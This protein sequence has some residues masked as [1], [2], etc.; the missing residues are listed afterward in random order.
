MN[1]GPI[2]YERDADG[3]VT[4]TWDC[5]GPVNVLSAQSVDAFAQ[6]VA[7]VLDD[8]GAV[9][10]VVASAKR[11]FIVGLDLNAVGAE[12]VA[13]L[14][15]GVDAFAATTRRMETGGKTFVAALAGTALGG[16]AELALA[17]HR[18]IASAGSDARFGFPEVTLGLIPGGGATQRLPRLSG[19]VQALPLLLEGRRLR[20]ADAAKLGIIDELVAD[21]ELLGAAKSWA[22]ANPRAAQPWDARTFVFPGG[23]PRDPG[24]AEALGVAA[25][26]LREKTWGNYPA[27]RD[28]LAAVYEGAL[29]DLESGLRVEARYFRAAIARPEARAMVKTLFFSMNRAKRMEARPASV[30]RRSFG[31]VGVVGAGTMG[32]GIALAAARAGA[33]AIVLDRDGLQAE[34][35]RSHA[36]AHGADAVT[37]ARIVPTTDYAAFAPC[38]LVIEAVFEDRAVK[39][40]VIARVEAN[41]RPE[42]ILAS[43]TSTLPIGSLAASSAQPERFVGI[44]FFSPVER[45]SLVE[46]IRGRATGDAALAAALDFAHFLGKTPIVVNDGR[47][48]FTSRVFATYVHEG[49]AMLREG[50]RPATIENAGRLAGMAVGP[51]AVA[52]EVGFALLQSVVEATRRDLGAAYVPG[53][54]DDVIAAFAVELARSG[55]TAGRGV[56]DYAPGVKKTLWPGLAE[57]WKP[58]AP[59]PDIE[60][61]KHRLLYVQAL[62]A[63]RCQLEGVIADPAMGDVASILGW[64]F[65]AFSGGVFSFVE[66]VGA[67]AFEAERARLAT[68]YGARFAA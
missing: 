5:A 60:T 23:T 12:R 54:A 48:F 40:D 11:D 51:L 6:A 32:A 50:V 20:L 39:E 10:A 18:R 47:G 55:K 25:A 17:C 61:V 15:D 67:D 41:V 13:S 56:Y 65:P 58:R 29:L 49:L 9:G 46:V 3:I 64:G 34:R 14:A 22:R 4:L 33:R 24:V 31:V 43:N 7:R 59:Q 27:T 63:R 19:I 36:T 38:D 1:D 35:A 2:R 44:H 68:A 57:R 45:M 66:F 37:L 42:C 28:L 26:R 53:A 62:E 21:A 30:P 8:S 52:D 16:G